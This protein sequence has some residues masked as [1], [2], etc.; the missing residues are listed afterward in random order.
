MIVAESVFLNL[1][2]D[3]EGLELS[4]R[5][6]EQRF[7]GRAMALHPGLRLLS[8]LTERAD[9]TVAHARNG[10]PAVVSW[11]EAELGQTLGQAA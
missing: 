10:R 2:I 8:H 4:A 6:R 5:L 11:R 3:A 7:R 9:S 1:I